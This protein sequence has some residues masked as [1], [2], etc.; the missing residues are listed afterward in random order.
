MAYRILFE[1]GALREL[2]RLPKDIQ[3]RVVA[4]AEAL[5]RDPRP[6][7]C[8]KLRGMED[9]FRVR[10]GDYRIVYRIEDDVLVVLVLSVGDRAD[11]YERLRRKG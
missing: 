11:V 10:V 1:D 7:G 9:L 5:E 2:R 6:S 8:K 4:K 3:R